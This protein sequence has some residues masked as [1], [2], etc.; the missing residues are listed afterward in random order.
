[1]GTNQTIVKEQ[2]E[3]KLALWVVGTE[4][5]EML[6]TVGWAR[7]QLRGRALACVCQV[8]GPAPG[9]VGKKGSGV[10]WEGG[11]ALCLQLMLQS[12]VQSSGAN[13]SE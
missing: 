11:R 5:K 1:M 10:S 3:E 12:N 6:K 4:R 7:V 9:T 2:T 8:P 13:G